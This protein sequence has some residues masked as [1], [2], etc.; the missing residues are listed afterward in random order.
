MRTVPIT[1]AALMLSTAAAAQTQ[2]R[3]VRY[4]DDRLA[5]IQEV[6]VVVSMT[7]SEAPPC[8]P[9]RSPLQAIARDT[10]RS[11]GV[12]ATVSE[13][14]SSWFY[15]L[16]LTLASTRVDGH[17]VTSL[18]TELMAEVEGIAAA[19]RDASPGA[20]GTL[21]VGHMPLSTAAELVTT[22]VSAHDVAVREAVRARVTSIAA[23]LR[24]ANK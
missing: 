4:G 24:L 14:A 11:A 19:D 8:V 12:K 7:S 23:R 9:S 18:A 22:P 15:S 1:L 6:D 5:G 20:W 2:V 3:V 21:L 16:V 17:C 10:L 13:K